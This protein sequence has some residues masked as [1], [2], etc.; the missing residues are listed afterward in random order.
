METAVLNNDKFVFV[1]DEMQIYQKVD[2][3][4]GHS[5]EREAIMY[6]DSN[7][8]YLGQSHGEA[9]RKMAVDVFS[10]NDKDYRPL[11][12]IYDRCLPGNDLAGKIR[13]GW[14]SEKYKTYTWNAYYGT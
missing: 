12:L 7:T 10:I 5:L 1:P 4:G 3:Y 6:V 14:W 2:K 8:I 13:H 11:S 9:F